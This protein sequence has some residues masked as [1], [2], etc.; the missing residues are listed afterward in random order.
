MKNLGTAFASEWTKERVTEEIERINRKGFIPI[1]DGMFRKDDG[2]IGQVL[3]REFGVDENNIHLADLGTYELKGLRG[4]KG[5]ISKLTLFHQTSTAGMTPIQ[6]FN[7]F[8]YCKRSVRDGSMKKKLFTTV[9]GNRQ[10][11]LGLI[12]KASNGYEV[13]CHAGLWIHPRADQCKTPARP[14]PLQLLHICF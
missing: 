10:N 3:E 2:V 9:K 14:H 7:R 13:L 1:S 11:N 5:R 4:R 8:C 12:L 6:L